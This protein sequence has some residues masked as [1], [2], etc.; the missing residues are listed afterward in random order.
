M[1]VDRYLLRRLDPIRYYPYSMDKRIQRAI[2]EVLGVYQ[3][4]VQ[5]A[6]GGEAMLTPP[7]EGVIRGESVPNEN[8]R[9][10]FEELLAKARERRIKSLE[11]QDRL[12]TEVD[13]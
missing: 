13:E 11:R 10:E 8:D 7:P 4:M 9:A 3:P 6:V 1:L 5:N 12:K 2:E